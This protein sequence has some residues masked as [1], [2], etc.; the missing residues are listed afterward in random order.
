MKLFSKYST[1]F[2]IFIISLVGLTICG[3]L[4]VNNPAKEI[5]NENLWITVVFFAFVFCIFYEANK[6]LSIGDKIKDALL[7]A[8]KKIKEGQINN[9]SDY[10]KAVIEDNHFFNNEVL[11]T[12]FEIYK[13]D[14]DSMKKYSSEAEIDIERYINYELIETSINTLFLNQITGAMTGLGIL[15]TFWGLSLGLSQFNLSGNADTMIKEIQP[16]MSGIKVAFHTSIYGIVYSLL[17]NFFYRAR[18]LEYSAAVSAFIETYQKHVV[19]ISN[20]GSEGSLIKNQNKIKACLDKQFESND[21]YFASNIE[22][23]IK[24]IGLQEHQNQATDVMSQQMAEQVSIMMKETIIPEIQKMREAVEIFAAE[25]RKDQKAGLE[26]IVNNF[27]EQMNS[28]LG[29]SFKELGKVLDETSKQQKENIDFTKHVIESMGDTAAGMDTVNKHIDDAAINVEKYTKAV[30]EMQ[31]SVNANLMSLNAQAEANNSL[32]E[33][34][35]EL[36]QL[37]TSIEENV[38]KDLLNVVESINSQSKE[39]ETRF[40]NSEEKLKEKIGIFADNINNITDSVL[41]KNSEMLVTFTNSCNDLVV[42]MIEQSTENQ[43]NMQ[44]K[45][46]EMTSE[47]IDKNKNLLEQISNDNQIYIKNVSD[48]TNEAVSAITKTNNDAISQIG[49]NSNDCI[50]TVIENSKAAQNQLKSGFDSLASSIGDTAGN[51]ENKMIS[52]VNRVDGFVDVWSNANSGFNENLNEELEEFLNTIK[53]ITNT[54]LTDTKSAIESLVDTSSKCFGEMAEN[55]Q[56]TQVKLYKQFS[57][58]EEII[59]EK[60]EKIKDVNEDITN[61]I[62]NAAENLGNA[63]KEL[64]DGLTSRI[65][66]T[67][68][69]FDKE[70]AEI[71]GHFSGTIKG[72]DKNVSNTK[73]AY[74]SMSDDIVKIFERMQDSLDQYLEY[75]DKLHHNIELKW[76]QLKT[77]ELN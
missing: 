23:Q 33:K 68:M 45:F 20:N 56:K 49:E 31:S 4:Y 5:D 55:T 25:A 21:K 61:D 76:N 53:S 27:I 44:N 48:F 36:I 41:S 77:K 7:N 42:K 43:S 14:I 46:N 28:S 74:D 64:D 9:N 73:Y 35:N 17:F 65:K 58:I 32:V 10:F 66:E 71:V 63:A 70:L 12:A 72:M 16:L 57:D 18:L 47:L 11:D 15:G 59:E 40:E 3:F 24:M 69:T 60:L 52:L 38:K 26:K 39:I 1:N 29:D 37:M 2:C 50:N 13:S 8:E 54:T 75:A 19:P 6:Y 22:N 51:I 62:S 34:Q 67:F 30:E